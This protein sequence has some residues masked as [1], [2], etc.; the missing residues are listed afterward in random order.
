VLAD[1]Q[2]DTLGIPLSPVSFV[3]TADLV[4]LEGWDARERLLRRLAAGPAAG[5]PAAGLTARGWRARH[6]SAASATMSSV[7]LRYVLILSC[8]SG[9]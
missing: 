3:T 5:W 9:A 7:M 1:Y 4:R 6:A 2:A 8:R